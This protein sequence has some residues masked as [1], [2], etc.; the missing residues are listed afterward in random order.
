MDDLKGRGAVVVGGGSGIGRGIALGLAAEG[1]RVLVA[2]IDSETA[3]AVENEI[4]R[5][6]GEAR[7]AQVDATDQQSLAALTATATSELDR[8]HI[9]A[10]TV[11]VHTDA[12]IITSTEEVW[13]WFIEFHL[14][15]A[16]RTVD[17]FVPLRQAHDDGGHIILT[18]SMAGLLV[19]STEQ[20]AATNTGVYT[21]LKHA[22]VGYGD[23][24]RHELA[25]D[26]IDVSV[27]CPGAVLTNLGTSSARHRP[28]RYGGP[29]PDPQREARQL[30]PSS[31][32]LRTMTP[33]ELGPI[34]VRGIKA[35]RQYILTHPDL[36]EMVRA[37]QSALLEDFAFFSAS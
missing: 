5:G 18:S 11:G 9:L 13:A 10:H 33:E 32:H 28:A 37:R 16:V 1:M 7:A 12:G 17:A 29:M 21:V 35:K 31:L 34:V 14:M 24:L 8:I 6:G 4:A 30:P 36:S 20:T 2:D 27:L 3:A 23:M 15:S 25:T 26:G 22:M 19:L